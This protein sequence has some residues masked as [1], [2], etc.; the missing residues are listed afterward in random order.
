MILRRNA[1]KSTVSQLGFYVQ[2]KQNDCQA[3]FTCKYCGTTKTKR[4]YLSCTVYMT[5]TTRAY[6][7][8]IVSY[9]RTKRKLSTTITNAATLCAN[10]QRFSN[11]GAD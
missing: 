10:L 7:S 3:T 9:Y 8:C 11:S 2:Q 5:I 1:E 4:Q 6:I